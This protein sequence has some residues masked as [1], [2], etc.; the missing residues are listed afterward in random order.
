MLNTNEC[1]SIPIKCLQWVRQLSVDRLF[2]NPADYILTLPNTLRSISIVLSIW[3]KHFSMFLPFLTPLILCYH[4]A[5]FC[6]FQELL[7]LVKSEVSF[8]LVQRFNF[9]GKN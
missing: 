4:I 7:D 2:W 3:G 9:Y 8:N 6:T 5:P 1:R